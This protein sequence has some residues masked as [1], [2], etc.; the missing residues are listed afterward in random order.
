MP[1]QSLLLLFFLSPDST[2]PAGFEIYVK[3]CE[4]SDPRGWN[5]SPCLWWMT[6]LR[7]HVAS[8]NCHWDL[9]KDIAC[10]S[11]FPVMLRFPS[12]LMNSLAWLF[13]TPAVSIAIGVNRCV[14]CPGTFESWRRLTC[15]LRVRRSWLLLAD[16]ATHRQI[17]GTMLLSCPTRE[18]DPTYAGHHYHMQTGVRFCF[19]S[20]RLLQLNSWWPSKV[21]HCAPT[22]R[23][24][25]S[26]TSDQRSRSTWPCDKISAWAALAINP[27]PHRVQVVPDNA[28]RPHRT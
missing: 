18:E 10:I 14:R 22:T 26:G 15:L 9:L 21:H 27:V 5:T 7:Q 23:L 2:K 6:P 17:H 19:E 12:S 3:V 25:C 20:T 11:Y 28:Q 24:E 13:H 1:P 4:W 8:L 16:A